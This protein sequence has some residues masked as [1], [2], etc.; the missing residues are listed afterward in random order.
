MRMGK[1]VGDHIN[2][3]KGKL[4]RRLR[5]ANVILFIV[6][7]LMMISV[8][9][10]IISGI[11]QSVSRDYAL[12]YSGNIIGKLNTYLGKEIALIE[13]AANSSAITGWMADESNQE[14]RRRAYE[15]MM[16]FIEILDSKNLYFGIEASHNEFSLDPGMSFEQ[17]Q[18]YDVLNPQRA[19]DVWYF[20]AVKSENDYVLNVDIDKVQSR[21]LVW[22]NYKVQKDGKTLGILCTGLLFDRVIEELFDEYDQGLLRNMVIDGNGIV[23]LDSQIGQEA[24]R[25]IYETNIFVGD[26]FPSKDFSTLV[27]AHLDTIDGYFD[28]GD[29]P[30]VGELSAESVYVAISPIESTDW[31][32]ITFYNSSALFGISQ[33]YPLFLAMI[34][35][36]IGYTWAINMLGKRMLL[37]PFGKLTASVASLDE[38]SE[39]DTIYGLERDD[40][41]GVLAQTIHGMK[42]RLDVYTAELVKAKDQ[43]ERGN[44][45]KSEFL[46]N[47]SHEIRTPMNTVIGMSQLAKDT[48]DIERSHYY[49]EKVETAGTHLL[50]VINDVLDMSK[51]ESGKFEISEGVIRFRDV[52]NKSVAVLG[53]RMEEKQQ[54]FDVLIDEKIPEYVISDDQ[55]LVQVVTNLLSNAV[56]FTP[57]QGSIGL[58]AKLKGQDGERCNIEVSVTDTGIGISEEQKQKLFQSFEQA[59]NGISRRFGGTGLGLAI[60]KKIVEL[61]GGDIG[62]ESQPGNGSRFTFHITAQQAQILN[63]VGTETA[64]QGEE[65]SFEGLRI[66]LVDD[67]EI[68]REILMALLESS[69]AVFTCAENGLMAVELFERS[70]DDF[71]MILMDIQMPELDGYGATK[72]IRAM[73]YPHAKAIPIIAMTANVFRE[74]VNRCLESGMNAHLGKPLEITE[75]IRMIKRFYK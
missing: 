43:A 73:E 54:Q 46:A 75:V 8:L 45:A 49:V 29:L 31:S 2:K 56:K 23:Q 61:M 39:S 48:Q 9:F 44:R 57:E 27:N 53:F 12:L 24:D 52:I 20:N 35:L 51:I 19:D 3:G 72:R 60:S 5:N 70:P 21:K 50:S 18:P 15:E 71:D 69:G 16:T 55:R 22:L 47:M 4:S 63:S 74:D 30:V 38:S 37:A 32:I 68:N 6:L 36:F 42:S 7:A 17:M 64:Q 14:K 11:V 25:L 1:K 26:Y 67:I 59:D 62:V 33:M 13:K 41:F 34:I 65:F 28:A 66:L 10:M 58:C 40:E